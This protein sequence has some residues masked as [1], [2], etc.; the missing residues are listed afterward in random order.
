MEIKDIRQSDGFWYFI[1]VLC[2]VT[3]R[4]RT[5]TPAAVS[6]WKAESPSDVI[7][8]S[9]AGTGGRGCFRKTSNLLITTAVHNVYLGYTAHSCKGRECTGLLKLKELSSPIWYA[10]TEPGSGL[11]SHIWIMLVC[12]VG[13]AVWPPD[14]SPEGQWGCWCCFS[15][16]EACV[17]CGPVPAVISDSIYR[18]FSGAE[19]I[20]ERL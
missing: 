8:R 4:N 13:S 19:V 15:C 2:W 5:V 16:P 9:G 11:S 6:L 1:F 14:I 3:W 10:S 17:A 20:S 7:A 18:H 12:L